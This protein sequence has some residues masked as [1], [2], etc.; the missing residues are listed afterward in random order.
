MRDKNILAKGM[1]EQCIQTILLKMNSEEWIGSQGVHKLITETA[2]KHR[3][4]MGTAGLFLTAVVAGIP[5]CYMAERQ[6][7][8]YWVLIKTSRWSLKC[9]LS[10]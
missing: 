3:V 7:L 10:L 1:L 6:H 8:R 2:I 5:K 9:I 4:A